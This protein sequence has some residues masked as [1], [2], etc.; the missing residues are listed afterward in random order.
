M[1]RMLIPVITFKDVVSDEKRIET[2]YA[3]IFEIARRN[4]LIKKQ[5]TNN[6]TQK[7]TEVQ[8]GKEISDNRRSGRNLKS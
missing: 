2:A 6:L 4:I 8:H 7:Y 5:L 3:R 1:N